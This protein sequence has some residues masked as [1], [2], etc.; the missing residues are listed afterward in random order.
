MD[1]KRIFIILTVLAAAPV[2]SVAQDTGQGS[3]QE[4]SV[5][6]DKAVSAYSGS[7]YDA[8]LEA[9]SAIEAEGY[10]SAGLYYN[11]ANCYFKKD[12]YLGKSILYYERALKED[13]SFED[14]AYNLE[15]ARQYT[16][17]KIDS[18]P[19]FILVTWF[20]SFRNSLSSD[21]WAWLSIGLFCL[22]AIFLLL[23]RFAA[24]LPLR[25]ASFSLAIITFVFSVTAFLF[26]FS[27]RNFAV[28]GS[29]AIVMTPVGSV[30]SSPGN[31]DQSLFILHEGTKVG[32]V[33]QLG[34]WY[35]IEL[36]DGR[37]GWT[38]KKNLEI[39]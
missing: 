7:D 28:E 3:G 33:D 2:M 1:M 9:F 37:Q 12:H 27:L 23:F 31:S 8:A 18:V 39:I 34:E 14:A 21:T 38:E 16:V 11:M 17:D 13:P 10:A 36:S 4:I 26:S 5:L 29:E 19:E 35:R 30:K 32:I 25:K 15:M 20:K 24:S 6:W 22:A